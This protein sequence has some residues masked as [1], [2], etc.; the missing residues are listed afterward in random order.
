VFPPA[1]FLR[2]A[3]RLIDDARREPLS[4]SN[5]ARVRTALGR[6]YYALYLL[7]RTEIMRRHGV[8]VRSLQHGAMY[9]RLQSPRASDEVRQLGRDLQLLYTLRQ[10]ADY[11]LDPAPSWKR[12]LEDPGGAEALVRRARE[13]A[14]TISRLDF[15]PIVS[16]LDPR[17]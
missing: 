3:T 7:V 14:G 10:K 8:P 2:L 15:S 1:E 9:T 17:G 13:L 4:E 6:A 16:L 5:A 11:E 12:Q